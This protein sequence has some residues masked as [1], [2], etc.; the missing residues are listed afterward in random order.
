MTTT[1]P[2]RPSARPGPAPAARP[3]PATPQPGLAVDEPEVR[4]TTGTWRRTDSIALVGSMLAGAGVTWLLFTQI[5]P[6]SGVLGVV[7][8]WFAL[9]LGI[10]VVVV[11][12]D[13][14]GQAVVDRLAL[15]V[16][17]ALAIV[18]LG[19]LLFVLTFVLSQGIEALRHANTFTQDL[20]LA[21]PLQPITVGGV[22]HGVVGTLEQIAIALTITVPLGIGC[23]VFLN[24]FRGPFARFV[25][26]IVEAMTALPS[27]VAGLFIYSTYILTFGFDKSGFAAALALSVMMLPIIIRAAD[28][29]LRLVP[30]SLK[31]ASFALGA[32][33][34]RTVWTV[35]LPTAKSGLTTAVIL[36]T[37]R[38]IGETSPVLLTAGFASTLNADPRSGPQV[39]LPLLAFELVK[40]PQPT[41]IARGFGAASILLILVLTLF[42]L[43]RSIGGRGPG[44]L[45]RRQQVRRTRRSRRDAER[46]IARSRARLQAPDASPAGTAAFP[47]IDPA[48]DPATDPATDPAGSGTDPA[49]PAAYPDLPGAPR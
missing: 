7:V 21:G 1:A 35:S 45:T 33:Q 47:A 34:W 11:S 20:T 42:F 27:I 40:F 49:L 36:G 26:T 13:E 16:I 24:E 6:F 37:A 17:H 39:S 31:E 9:F 18:L 3:D 4:R 12:L 14:G 44:N 22:L 41:M 23:A 30:G 15:V 10:Y 28:V 32:G 19:A 43:A 46:F 48:I 8:V 5:A 25:R 29:V 38:G 2:N